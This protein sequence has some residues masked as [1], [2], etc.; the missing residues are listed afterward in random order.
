MTNKQAAEAETFIDNR[1]EIE[2][3]TELRKELLKPKGQQNKGKIQQYRDA[4]KYLALKEANYT[5]GKPDFLVKPTIMSKN[6]LTDIELENNIDAV[7]KAT[8]QFG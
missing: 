1:D 3:R 6:Q 2:L 7:R 4:L 8:E 5:F